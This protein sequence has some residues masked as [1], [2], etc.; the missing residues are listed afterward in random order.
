MAFWDGSSQFSLFPHPAKPSIPFTRIHND[1]WG[2]TH[3]P[4]RTNTK[5][6]ITFIDDHTPICW[7]YVLRDK[8]EVR[9]IF[10]NCHSIIQ[11]QFHTKI[12]VLYTDNDTKYFNQASGSSLLEHG[13]VHQS[14][15]VGTPQQNGIAERKKRHILE[16]A[17][18]LLFTT[19]IKKK[20]FGGML[21]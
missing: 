8:T 10:I 2:L 21:S 5:W 16:F 1:L 3:T 9:T 14:S 12:Q 17:C 19:N 7:T 13:I 6:F 20:P 15:C 4:N 11:T 18:A